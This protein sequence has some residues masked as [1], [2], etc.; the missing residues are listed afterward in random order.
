MKELVL[1]ALK[2]KY[3]NLGFDDSVLSNFAETISSGV[4]EEGQIE[5]AINAQSATFTALQSFIDKRVTTAVEKV[6]APAPANP[7]PAPANPNP[8][9]GD[10]IA[11]LISQALKPLQDQI[12][13]FQNADISK[14]RGSKVNEVLS[15]I[16]NESIRTMLQDSF[17]VANFADNDSF[18]N[19]FTSLN[20]KVEE[21][22]KTESANSLNTGLPAM[23]FDKVD[24]VSS[25]MKEMYPKQS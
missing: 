10:N 14:V 9:P 17:S 12:A 23:S 20:S 22:V 15:K 4:T 16:K 11:E 6:K 8:N 1:K 7:N 21:L 5:A 24:G 19:Y 13:S 18:D 2:T 25:L 3:S